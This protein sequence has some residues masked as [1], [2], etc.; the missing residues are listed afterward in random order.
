MSP[1]SMSPAVRPA[2]AGEPTLTGV[3]PALPGDDDPRRTAVRAWLSQ[4]PSPTARQL[5]ERGLVAPHWPEPYGLGADPTGQ[6]VVDDELRRAGVRR[7]DNPIGIGW[8]G[9]TL[10]YAGTEAQQERYLMPMLAGEEIWCQ[11]FSEPDAGSDLA[12]ITTRAEPDGDEWVV[13][14]RKVWTSYAHRARFG[15]LLARTEPGAPAHQAISYFICPM[16]A[17]GVEVRPLP[18][19][20]G[21]HT[22]NEVF[23]DE[24][25]LPAGSMVG[26]AGPGVVTG[27]GDAGQR[28]GLA[29]DRWRAVGDGPDGR[30][31]RRRRA[32]GGRHR[33][34]AVP[35]APGPGV[36]RGRGVAPLA[37]ADGG[38]RHLRRRA[39]SRGVGAQGVGRRSWSA[40]HGPGPR[41]GRGPGHADPGR[42][43]GGP[44]LMAGRRLELRV[45]LR[46]GPHHRW[47]AR[48][49]CSATSSPSGPSAYPTIRSPTAMATPAG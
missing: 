11:L 13:R 10:L 25:R 33:R 34:P 42:Y 32:G 5:A 40:P 24:V 23:L 21:T 17:D 31:P 22:F 16:D 49:R 8:A 36:G 12:S 6:L 3:N 47:R 2:N 44:R 30:R 37:D 38:H 4:H 28:A 39:R 26:A 20:T 45:P 48:P 19:M 7:P 35:S 9:P 46:P 43:Q 41:P 15:I 14:G 29:L 27:Q 18:D 1:S